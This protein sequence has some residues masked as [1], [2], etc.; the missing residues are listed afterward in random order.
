MLGLIIAVLFCLALL[1]KD[2]TPAR[3]FQRSTRFLYKWYTVVAV[4]VLAISF[5]LV[6][7]GSSIIGL[8]VAGLPGWVVGVLTGG[9]LAFP[10][11]LYLSL[12][13]FLQIMGARLMHGSVELGASG[14]ASWKVSKLV[15]GGASLAIG[16]FL[17]PLFS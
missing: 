3:I 11:F 2:E 10:F 17:L 7:G 8:L 16:L 6:L 12:V 5:L 4:T 15:L 14:P 9:A 13:Y 1:S